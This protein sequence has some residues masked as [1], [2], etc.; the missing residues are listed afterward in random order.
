[1]FQTR[2]ADF[3]VLFAGNEKLISDSCSYYCSLY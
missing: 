2:S 3:L 1:M